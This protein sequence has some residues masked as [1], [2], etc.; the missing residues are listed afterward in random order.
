MNFHI[1]A[2]YL[3]T[4]G[5][6]PEVLATSEDVDSFIDRLL[7][8]PKQYRLAQLHLRERPLIRGEF[9]D[10]QFYVGVDKERGVGVLQVADEDGNWV[11]RS[12]EGG[13]LN[14]ITSYCLIYNGTEFQEYSDLPLDLIRRAVREFLATGGKRPTCVPWQVETL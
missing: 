6:Y 9:P 14:E 5:D 7:E 2:R 11:S 10:H 3:E 8:M 4:H 13:G 1:E 12:L